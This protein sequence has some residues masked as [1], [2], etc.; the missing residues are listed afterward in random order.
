MYIQKIEIGDRVRAYDFEEDDTC[1]VEGVVEAIVEEEA[2]CARYKIKM[3]R[4]VLQNV[5]RPYS[6]KDEPYVYPPVNGTLTLFGNRTNYVI[7][8][9]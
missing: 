6:W 9:R 1:Y 2:D 4:R 8:V 3:E 7:R 5:E